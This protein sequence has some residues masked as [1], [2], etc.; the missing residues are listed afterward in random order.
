MCLRNIST[1]VWMISVSPSLPPS[2]LSRDA[3][4]RRNW[5]RTLNQS[6]GR[7]VL[8]Y[9]AF[10]MTLL[11]EFLCSSSSWQYKEWADGALPRLEAILWPSSVL[12]IVTNGKPWRT[13]GGITQKQKFGTARER[14]RE[15]E[16]GLCLQMHFGSKCRKILKCLFFGA[17][18][19]LSV[20]RNCLLPNLL[21]KPS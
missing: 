4:G 15:R 10:H 9:Q 14:E 1:V 8:R 2:P 20:R 6:P 12:N 19:C 5:T 7:A 18:F 13:L 11:T 17:N 3:S 21:I 16:G